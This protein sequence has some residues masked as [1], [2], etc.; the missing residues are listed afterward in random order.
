MRRRLVVLLVLLSAVPTLYAVDLPLK[1]TAITPH[2]LMFRDYYPDGK[3]WRPDYKMTVDFTIQNVSK[4]AIDSAVLQ[5]G[6][7]AKAINNYN[8][9]SLQAKMFNLQ[10]KLQPG[11]IMTMFYGDVFSLG[12]N[13][14]TGAFENAGGSV[15]ITLL[16]LTYADG[17]LADFGPE[18]NRYIG[19]GTVPQPMT[20]PAS[21][22][23]TPEKLS[24]VSPP[25][26]IGRILGG[27]DLLKEYQ[28]SHKS[29]LTHAICDSQVAKCN[30][31]N[32][33]RNLRGPQGAFERAAQFCLASYQQCLAEA[34]YK[35]TPPS[36]TE[37]FK[38]LID[39][40]GAVCDVQL[41]EPNHAADDLDRLAIKHLNKLLFFPAVKDGVP[42]AVWVKLNV[43]LP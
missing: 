14:A 40:S 41:A 34:D 9:A 11:Q 5:I 29:G 28:D 39:N 10:L 31:D 30:A 13:S 22:C 4:S 1:I 19:V 2:V 15:G 7:G 38:L 18:Y 12:S 8:A 43:G 27:V 25:R 36:R 21:S 42:V 35:S 6:V 3:S 24:E 23:K 33:N 37:S 20:L 17:M 26:E 16:S 32:N